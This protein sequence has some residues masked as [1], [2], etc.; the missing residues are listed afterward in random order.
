MKPSLK[1]EIIYEFKSARRSVLFGLLSVLSVAGL[2]AYQFTPLSGEGIKSAGELLQF[3]VDK[4]SSALP[5][6][7]AYKTAYYYNI[8]QLLFVVAFITNDTRAARYRAREVFH[9]RPVS[10]GEIVL[11]SFIGKL[12]V[13]TLVNVLTFGAAMWINAL[14][15]PRSFTWWAYGF[16]WLTFNLPTL[17]YLLGLAYL[18][19]RLVRHQGGSLLLLLLVAGGLTWWGAGPWN[20]LADPCARLVPNLFSDF[21]GH[22][23]PGPYLLHRL[24]TL[25]AGLAFLSLSLLPYPRIPNEIRAAGKGTRFAAGFCLLAAAAGFLFISLHERV[26]ERRSAYRA[27]Y[28]RHGQRSAARVASNALAVEELPD[29]GIS[30]R[31]EMEVENRTGEAISPVL[32]LNP[33]LKINSLEMEGRE[34]KFKRTHQAVEIDRVLQ[35]GERVSLVL[36]YEGI[37][38]PEVCFLDTRDD[39]YFSPGVNTLGI[40]RFGQRPVFCERGYKLLTPESLWYPV[41]VAP[42]GQGGARDVNFSRYSLRVKHDPRLTAIAQGGVRETGKGE[43]VF[44]F[45]HDMPGLSLCIG[46]YKQRSIVKNAVRM[47]LYYLPEHEYLLER[48]DLIAE[49]VKDAEHKDYHIMNL[50]RDVHREEAIQTSAHFQAM[51]RYQVTNQPYTKDVTQEYPYEWFNLVEVPCDFHVFPNLNNGGG[52]RVESG[53]MFLPEKMYSLSNYPRQIPERVE[54]IGTYMASIGLGLDMQAIFGS[55]GFSMGRQLRGQTSFLSS[56]G[57][58]SLFHLLMDMVHGYGKAAILQNIQDEAQNYPIVEYLKR[59]SL[60]EA[61]RDSS[62]SSA[63]LQGVLKKKNEELAVYIQNH[64]RQEEFKTFLIDFLARNKF[65]E[66]P[67]EQFF[68]DFQKEFGVRLDS[69][70][71]SWYTRKGLARFE[72]EEVRVFDV[73]GLEDPYF[74]YHFKVFN[75]GNAPGMVQVQKQKAWMIPPGEGREIRALLEGYG[76][77]VLSYPFAQ[78]IPNSLFL[79]YESVDFR[80]VDTSYLEKVLDQAGFSAPRPDEIIV[81]NED[82]GFRVVRRE[83][84]LTRWLR[85]EPGKTY[86]DQFQA[87]AW[88]PLIKY[89]FFGS[90][91]RSA[92]VK[93][94]GEGRQKVEWSTTLPEAG[95]YEVFFYHTRMNH[96]VFPTKRIKSAFSVR[97]SFTKISNDERKAASSYVTQ[98]RAAGYYTVFDG[99][100]EHE[101]VPMVD[102]DATNVWVSLGVFDFSKNAKVTLCDK[103][104]DKHTTLIA[105]AVKWAKIKE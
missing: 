35:P 68:Q 99:K 86:Y 64:V 72:F 10:N 7:I 66:V 24:F 100:Q 12:L 15:Y 27:V 4:L 93:Q 74:L 62:L 42:Y 1:T 59:H 32:F 95:K 18:V 97:G 30:V 46:N 104:V 71:G 47:A 58:F 90:P 73:T 23:N 3:S 54:D 102:K 13:F 17:V 55:Q 41:C 19:T 28:E 94:A 9:T 87:G 96:I 78:N 85:D 91:T 76:E 45:T 21:T 5:A 48:Y 56:P 105:D 22:V 38:E 61:L 63:L 84:L 52:E 26:K 65:R 31:S 8:I 37:A 11:G 50:V 16:Y 60:Q 101:V 40:F 49:K 82:P 70:M 51:I 43:T 6:S 77:N 89:Q 67:Q 14:F 33:G 2:V 75:R 79:R 98:Q 88:V 34:V 44:A 92:H 83:N 103:P 39:R 36:T 57:Q 25:L 53:M 69:I 81:D 80:S 20:G 29:G